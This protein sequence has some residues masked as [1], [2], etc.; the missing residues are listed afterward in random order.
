[1]GAGQSQ[2]TETKTVF[3]NENDVSD[4]YRT[5]GVSDEVVNT[6]QGKGG[7]SSSNKVIVEAATDPELA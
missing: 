3:I 1:M 5:V 7:R 4:A 6:V 2:P